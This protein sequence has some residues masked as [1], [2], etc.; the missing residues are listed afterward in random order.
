LGNDLAG[1]NIAPDLGW[2]IGAVQ[3]VN[4]IP[5]LD[6]RDAGAGEADDLGR[7][8]NTVKPVVPVPALFEDEAGVRSKDEFG[9]LVAIAVFHSI[10]VVAHS[11][12]PT[13]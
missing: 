8:V 1:P 10:V 4:S 5:S 6:S 12:Y 9:G 2:S 7:A 11:N 3:V 13:Q